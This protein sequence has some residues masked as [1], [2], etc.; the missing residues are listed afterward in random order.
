MLDMDT[1]VKLQEAVDTAKQRIQELEQEISSMQSHAIERENQLAEIKNNFKKLEQDYQEIQAKHRSLS[2]ELS[3]EQVHKVSM[4]T[5]WEAERLESL[6]TVERYESRCLQAEADLQQLRLAAN[7]LTADKEQ[8]LQDASVLKSQIA[9]KEQ[10]IASMLTEGE[11]LKATIAEKEQLIVNISREGGELRNQIEENEQLIAESDRLKSTIAEKDQLIASIGLEGERLAAKITE[12]TGDID[13][14]SR[15]IKLRDDEVNNLQQELAIAKQRSSENDL[16]PQESSVLHSQLAT[17]STTIDAKV[18]EISILSNNNNDLQNRLSLLESDL[19]AKM[20]DKQGS[21]DAV[22]NEARS[23]QSRYEESKAAHSQEVQDLKS[24]VVS[25]TEKASNENAAWKS[26]VDKL[27]E[28]IASMSASSE[29][30]DSLRSMNADYAKKLSELTAESE[31]LQRRLQEKEQQIQLLETKETSTHQQ[32]ENLKVE[33]DVLAHQLQGFQS[34]SSHDNEHQQPLEQQL[35]QAQQERVELNQKHEDEIAALS[36]KMKRLKQLLTRTKNALQDREAE[37]ATLKQDLEKNEAASSR[38]PSR[39]RPLLCLSSIE[40]SA[41][42]MDET[43]HAS[44][45]SDQSWILIADAD[46]QQAL[47]WMKHHELQACLAQGSSLT[48]DLPPPLEQSYRTMIG[49]QTSIYQRKVADLQQELADLNES[50]TAYKNRAQTALK[51]LGGDDHKRQLDE[52]A[53][54]QQ[55]QSLQEQIHEL[56]DSNREL[57]EKLSEQLQSYDTLTTRCNDLNLE[58]RDLELKRCAIEEEKL[59]LEQRLH[60]SDAERLR[61]EE[62]IASLSKSS[63]S[64]A[65][66]VNYANTSMR[67]L[68]MRS[69]AELHPNRDSD[70][71]GEL[72]AADSSMLSPSTPTRSSPTRSVAD[73]DMSSVVTPNTEYSRHTSKLV[74]LKQ[75]SDMPSF[76]LLA[77]MSLH[78][79]S[80]PMKRSSK[81]W[82]R[83]ATRMVA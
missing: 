32:I 17:L 5:S 9:E 33:R 66:A 46:N 39:M 70:E 62:Q 18:K 59:Q 75:V 7:G 57:K 50:F 26:R 20:A 24:K 34:T 80:R 67:G 28:Q 11:S 77:L 25:I 56:E 38:K 10:L 41:R 82:H 45:L 35:A 81:L 8:L 58:F 27:N 40:M 61:L 60:D 48:E 31:A 19:Q 49:E 79:Y 68:E 15:V 51:R 43:E 53:Y 3:Q 47:R 23:L 55:I 73:L 64:S 36:E 2:E 21:L 52:Q 1:M 65:V 4:E 30:S 12:M 72:V 44:A 16:K 76:L 22:Q 74:L 29:T 13:E 6:Q 54:Q 69:P 37:V 63:S 71:E 83:C 42:S 14:L 78:R